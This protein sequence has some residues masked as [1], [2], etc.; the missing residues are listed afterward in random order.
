MGDGG[1]SCASVVLVLVPTCR[2]AGPVTSCAAGGAKACGE[3]VLVQVGEI[4]LLRLLRPTAEDALSEEDKSTTADRSADDAEGDTEAMGTVAK[5]ERF[6]SSGLCTLDCA[7][8]EADLNSTSDANGAARW[9][10]DR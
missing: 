8:D 2:L 5:E 10:C 7:D 1:I 9:N 4:S 3:V 6:D